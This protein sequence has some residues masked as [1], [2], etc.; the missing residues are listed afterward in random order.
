MRSLGGRE[1]QDSIS[2]RVSAR[3]AQC[4][5]LENQE[6]VLHNRARWNPDL[7][8]STINAGGF[9][10]RS[11]WELSPGSRKM[12]ESRGSGGCNS[13]WGSMT[14]KDSVEGEIHPIQAGDFNDSGTA[15]GRKEVVVDLGQGACGGEVLVKGDMVGDKPVIEES[16]LM[17]AGR[18]FEPVRS[19]QGDKIVVA[20]GGPSGSGKSEIASL[21]GS[22]F[23]REGRNSYVLS[24]DNYPHRPPRI[25]DAERDSLYKAHGERG[26]IDYLGTQREIDFER[27]T[28]LVAAFKSGAESLALRIMD[29][30][31]SVVHK[32]PR[33]LDVSKINVLVLEGTWSHQVEG[34]DYRIFL[35]TTPEETRAHRLKRG[36]DPLSAFGELV[37]GIEQAKLEVLREKA[38]LVIANSG[39]TRAGKLLI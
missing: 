8:L 18:V 2:G 7:L 14:G 28:A 12:M 4:H 39:A 1:V 3:G 10:F 9:P 35:D 17:R 21:I 26:L 24:C 30:A 32:D 29:A 33:M 36:R 27:L 13:S 15:C 11:S 25:N 31:T 6:R 22:M 38:N 16:H 34:C 37:L 5:H 20:V 23:I 19:L